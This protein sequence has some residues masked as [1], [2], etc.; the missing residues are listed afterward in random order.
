M[1]SVILAFGLAQISGYS[2]GNDVFGDFNFYYDYYAACFS[3]SIWYFMI[4]LL[5]VER[6]KLEFDA[7]AFLI[8]VI[9]FLILILFLYFD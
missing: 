3:V 2:D 7:Q 5:F 4:H 9:L 8:F 6:I 1:K